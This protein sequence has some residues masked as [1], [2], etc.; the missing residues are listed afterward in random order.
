ML[1]VHVCMDLLIE[2]EL[3]DFQLVYKLYEEGGT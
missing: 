1:L 2:Y 3:F